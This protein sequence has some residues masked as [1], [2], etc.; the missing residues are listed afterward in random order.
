MREKFIEKRFSKGSL[1]AIENANK[2]IAEYQAQ[3]YSLTLRQVYYQFVARGLIPNNMKSYKNL[4]SVINDGRLAG[5]IDWDAIEDRTRNLQ[6]YNYIETVADALRAAE[7]S[8][9]VDKWADQDVHVEVWVEK[10]ALVGVVGG[11]CSRL[12]VDYLAC[13]GYVSQSEQYNAGQRFQGRVSDGKK[14]IIL[15][16][17][18]HDP[19]GID[20][21]R[22]NQERL[23]LFTQNE[24]EVRRLAL[25]MDQVR[26]YNPPPNPAKLTDSRVG[27][28]IKRFGNQSWELDALEPS[29]IEQLIRENVEELRDMEKWD[30]AEARQADKRELIADMRRDAMRKGL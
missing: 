18:D 26:A 14:V 7:R 5:L 15:H 10:E 19:S 12:E 13:R 2:I 11:I 24:V 28:Y 29:F 22:D 1:V 30:A 21:T 16:L 8:L 6:G 23:N 25:N 3:G 17:G 9:I 20:M 4:G 27:G